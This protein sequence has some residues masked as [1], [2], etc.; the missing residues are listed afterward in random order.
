M[1]PATAV[2]AGDRRPR[3]SCRYRLTRARRGRHRPGASAAALRPAGPPGPRATGSARRCSP[4]SPA[5][6]PST[7]P[8]ARP[9]R[10]QRGPRDRGPVPRARARPPSSID[11]RGRRGCHPGQ[12]G[13]AGR[14]WP[15][16]AT[17]VRADAAPLRAPAP[18]RSDLVLAD[19]PYGFEALGRR[20]WARWRPGPDCSWPR[21]A[22]EWDP[23]PG[24]ETVKVKRYGGTVV[25]VV[26]PAVAIEAA[27]ASRR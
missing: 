19:P 12:P 26:Q 20:C 25:T 24:W 4:C 13:G 17:V 14:R 15:A 2:D 11:D 10:G 23:G 5:W 18:R 21:P 1:G 8:G 9:V 6:T 7:G 16:R 3:G 27:T 22:A